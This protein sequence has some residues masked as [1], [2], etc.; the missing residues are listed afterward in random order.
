V[1]SSRTAG[2]SGGGN[3]AMEPPSKSAS[4]IAMK[5]LSDGTVTL[6]P[7]TPDDAGMV[8]EW[9]AGPGARRSRENAGGS[10]SDGNPDPAD[11]DRLLTRHARDDLFIV[12]LDVER[13]GV[14]HCDPQSGRLDLILATAEL[15]EQGIGS[16]AAALLLHHAFDIRRL[17]SVGVE[18][19]PDS[20]AHGRLAWEEAGLAQVRRRLLDDQVF[21]DLEISRAC[22]Q[23]SEEQVFLIRHAETTAD[24]EQ[25]AWSQADSRLSSMGRAQTEALRSCDLLFRVGECIAS[26]HQQARATAERIFAVRNVPCTVDEAWQGQDLGEWHHQHLRDLPR[27]DDGLLADP[28]GGE[29]T[30]TFV[31]RVA[32]ALDGLPHGEHLGIVTHGDVIAAVLRHVAPG[33]GEA[34]GLTSGAGIGPATVTE[35]R[36]GPDGWR[37]IRIAEDK[38]LRAR[39]DTTRTA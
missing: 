24:T 10:G 12:V 19:L 30:A 4:I 25:L 18:G 2:T 5:A 38:H 33:L 26:P 20:G 8:R 28:P 15:W 13:C 34:P 6:Q 14:A 22:H 23:S 9:L 11:P 16:R 17:K 7:Y 21:I 32:T 31:K 27:G 39:R 35:L 36:R 1:L 3:A 37:V 29:T